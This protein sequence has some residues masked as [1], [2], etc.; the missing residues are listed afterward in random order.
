MML[1]SFH[2][3]ICLDI[4]G[5]ETHLGLPFSRPSAACCAWSLAAEPRWPRCLFFFSNFRMAHVEF[6]CWHWIRELYYNILYIVMIIILYIYISDII[7]TYMYIFESYYMYCLLVIPFFCLRD[8]LVNY[9]CLVARPWWMSFK[10]RRRVQAEALGGL[11]LG[12]DKVYHKVTSN[13]GKY[14]YNTVYLCIDTHF[15]I[16]V[17]NFFFKHSIFKMNVT[18]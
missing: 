10:R 11:R 5:C 6:L 8:L 14:R 13:F 15:E 17:L 16:D 7:Y 12:H 2:V 3:L 9:L 18:N 4:F 1:T